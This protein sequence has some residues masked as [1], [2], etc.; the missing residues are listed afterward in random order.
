MTVFAFREISTYSRK[1]FCAV[2]DTFD[3]LSNLLQLVEISNT[4]FSDKLDEADKSHFD[5]AI[6]TGRFRRALIRKDDGFFSMTI[7]FQV[8]YNENR[9][10]FNYDPFGEEVNGQFISIMRNAIKTAK[11][12]TYSHEEIIISIVEDFRLSETEANKYYDIFACLV[13]EDHGYFRFDDDIK[14]ENGQIHPR[15]HFDFFI[16]NTSG[17]KIGY[18]K[19]MDINAFYRL[20]DKAQPKFYMR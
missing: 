6:F 16:K 1:K 8:I 19:P 14:N 17:V 7:P 4:H 3:N 10:S 15:Y 12:R 20:V 9:L 13:C 18:T 2:R 5:I 11:E